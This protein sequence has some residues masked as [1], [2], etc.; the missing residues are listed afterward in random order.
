MA[1]ARL[2][3]WEPLFRRAITLLES[4]GKSA[5]APFEWSMGGGTVLML[6]H[7]HRYSRDIDIFLRDPQY[8]GYL[9]PRLSE[10]AEQMTHDYD[11]AAEYLK[12][13]FPEGEIDFIA[14]G[15]LTPSPYE[16][17][18]VLDHE[19]N[20]ETSAEIIAKKVRYRA[21]TFKA[22]DLFDVAIVKEREPDQIEAIRPI[23][24]AYR[25]QIEE[26]IRRNRKALQEEY[27]ELELFDNVLTLE[28]CIE[29]LRN[30]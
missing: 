29:H 13:R 30:I 4:A 6:R 23:I 15:W 21:D 14:S 22:R 26:R 10:V 9:N 20:L 17:S 16:K 12:L 28:R 5:G 7:Q 1:Q 11:E 24:E 18:S 8:L 27:H 25:G 19:A 3:D 2:N